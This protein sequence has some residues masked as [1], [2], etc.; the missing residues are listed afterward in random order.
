NEAVGDPAE[1]TRDRAQRTVVDVD[2]P[3][4]GDAAQVQFQGVAPVDVVVHHR[5]EQVVGRAD[6]VHVPGE[7]QVDVL[8]RHDLGVAAAGGAAFHAEAGPEARLAQ[9]HHG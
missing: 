6:G 2:D 1:A 7:M 9:A 8:H 3:P 4:P 5:R